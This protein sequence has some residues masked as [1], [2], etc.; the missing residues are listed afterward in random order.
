M[1]RDQGGTLEHDANERH[2]NGD[3]VGN[4]P[5]LGPRHQLPGLGI[6][7]HQASTLLARTNRFLQQ[8]A[9]TRAFDRACT[10][11]LYGLM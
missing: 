10:P 6:A 11:Q 8:D 5:H 4:G 2:A 7:V 3:D 1:K 9:A